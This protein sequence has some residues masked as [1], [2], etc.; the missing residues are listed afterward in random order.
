MYM[1]MF[2]K[3][4]KKRQSQ[5]P[6]CFLCLSIEVL[7]RVEFT[8]DSSHTTIVF[9]W[10]ANDLII[11]NIIKFFLLFLC[12]CM[13]SSIDPISLFFHLKILFHKS[14][15]KAYIAFI[16]II[17]H[18]FIAT[19]KIYFCIDVGHKFEDTYIT[20]LEITELNIFVLVF[21]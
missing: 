11:I 8:H 2:F 5:T 6:L 15:T 19:K 21:M 16:C 13:S 3:E 14:F 7:I 17:G 12:L 20:N 9:D 4:K 10:L 18:H 1:K